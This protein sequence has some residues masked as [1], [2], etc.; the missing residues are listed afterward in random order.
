M[1]KTSTLVKAR[2][3]VGS[4]SLSP[5]TGLRVFYRF[6]ETVP[7]SPRRKNA[8]LTRLLAF[9]LQVSS[10]DVLLIYTLCSNVSP[11]LSLYKY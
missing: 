5:I 11:S 8:E 7:S 3:Q 2:L 6:E 1:A 9:R 4:R 10:L